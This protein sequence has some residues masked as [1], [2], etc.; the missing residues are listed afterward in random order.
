M[1]NNIAMGLMDKCV[2]LTQYQGVHSEEDVNRII[3]ILE[4]NLSE[5]ELDLLADITLTEKR[6]S[7]GHFWLRFFAAHGNSRRKD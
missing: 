5:E 7:S 6:T 1:G 3:E 4:K 2:A